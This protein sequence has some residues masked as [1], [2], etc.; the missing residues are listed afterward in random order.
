MHIKT[1][2]TKIRKNC[3]RW[4]NMHKK[5]KN[6]CTLTKYAQKIEKFVHV[7]KYAQKN[8]PDKE[9]QMH[10]SCNCEKN[11]RIKRK[12][13]SAVCVTKKMLLTLSLLS[14]PN[15]LH[16]ILSL[17]GTCLIL[18]RQQKDWLFW[19]LCLKRPLLWRRP[20]KIG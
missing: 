17:R 6:L 11:R 20:S 8:V 13:D 4:R 19:N 1:I 15:F 14:L 16:L 2:C 9:K 10:Y 18:S 12:F 7:A 3:A 5:S